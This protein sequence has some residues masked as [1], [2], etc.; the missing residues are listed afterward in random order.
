M[1]LKERLDIRSI[2]LRHLV[3][4]DKK[5]SLFRNLDG[6]YNLAGGNNNNS[7]LSNLGTLGNLDRVGNPNIVNISSLSSL[8]RI[9]TNKNN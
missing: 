7:V 5:S 1:I 3:F 6:I 9:T 8:I 4:R 2:I